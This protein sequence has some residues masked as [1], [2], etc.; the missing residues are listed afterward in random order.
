MSCDLQVNFPRWI[1]STGSHRGASSFQHPRARTDSQP[2]GA[3][4]R[5]TSIS[6]ASEELPKSF[7]SRQRRQEVLGRLVAWGCLGRCGSGWKGGL[8]LAAVAALFL[9]D[10]G[11]AS[12]R[13]GE[14]KWVAA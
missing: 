14:Q 13:G 3:G 9:G 10:G 7:S 6:R 4:R 11:A 12:L 1:K 8:A 5:G 2:M